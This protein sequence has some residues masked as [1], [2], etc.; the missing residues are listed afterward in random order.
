MSS[1]TSITI[2][3]ILGF[4]IA[5]TVFY[6][7]FRGTRKNNVSEG[8]ALFVGAIAFTAIWV[9]FISAFKENPNENVSS[10]TSDSPQQ[11]VPVVVPETN[12]NALAPVTE[13][14]TNDETNAAPQTFPVIFTKDS[15]GYDWRRANFQSRHQFCET[16]AEAE[17]KEFNHEF[18]AD[19]YYGALDS[20]YDSSDPNILEQNIHQIVGLTTSA[21]MAN[22]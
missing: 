6:F 7:T 14:I 3:T 12:S 5:S 15:N 20:F 17:S 1:D 11:P 10:S 2:G 4:I 18:T 22:Q 8:K 13:S 21:A 9:L 19:F 16:V